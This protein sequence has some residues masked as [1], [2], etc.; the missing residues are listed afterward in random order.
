[1][2]GTVYYV[3]Q[4]TPGSGTID[5]LVMPSY[6]INVPALET[7][8]YYFTAPHDFIIT[9]LR[10][11]V[12][13]GGTVSGIAVVKL[14]SAPPLYAS[15]TNTF[16]T[17]YL[18]QNITGTNVVSVNIPVFSGDIIGVLGERGGYS[19]YGPNQGTGTFSSTL[20]IG[21]STVTLNRMG[22]LYN[23]ATT[24]PQD[25]WTEQV[26][27]IGIVEMYVSKVCNSSLTP[28]SVSVVGVPQVTVTPPPHVCANAAYTLTAGGASTY[29]WTG[30]PQS[31]TYVVNPS[32]T[33]TYSVQGSILSSC[34]STLSTVTITVDASAPTITA[35]ASSASI[36]S[37]NTVS[38]NGTG[39][40]AA[41]FTWNG[42]ANNV[43]NNTPFSPLATQL[44]TLYGTNACGTT[45][46]GITVTVHATP[47]LVTSS[48]DP[49]GV[50]EGNS[51]T[52]TATGASTYSWSNV[53]APGGSVVIIPN[54]G[55]GSIPYNV[56]GVSNAGCSSSTVHILNVLPNPTVSAVSNKQIVCS[57]GSAT[58][59]ASGANSYSW[60]NN[61]VVD[62]TT[63]VNPASTTVYTVTGTYTSNG[64]FA[65]ATVSVT[66]FDPVL[67]VSNSTTVCE[68]AAI[69]LTANATAGSSSTYSWSNGSLYASNNITVTA[70]AAY[71]V[72]VTT[73]APGVFGCKTTA[74]VNVGMNANPTVSI[75]ATK[76]VICK[77][78][79]LLLTASGG[80]T[81]IW[82]SLTPTTNTIF[83]N[84]NVVNTTTGY[85]VTGTD[86]NGCSNTA[87]IG[88]RVNACTGIDQF[89]LSENLVSVY[90]NPNNGIFMIQVN[91]QSHLVLVN[92][93]GQ[94]VKDLNFD[95]SNNYQMEVSD[96]SNGIY[97]IK[98]LSDGSAIRNKIVVSK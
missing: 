42:G 44:Y 40:P 5:T 70:P 75:S 64:C 28:V 76:T 14:P 87:T 60:T 59:T 2:Q 27:T 66:V 82:K 35:S 22:M 15:V 83:V 97:F 43:S 96:L 72:T 93:L 23:L 77:G 73:N 4:S 79:K 54:S 29:T 7:R 19:A 58:L 92:Q 34:N 89:E 71:V 47:T 65:D 52:L 1:T 94:V 63:A 51:T 32:T 49:N 10:V 53:S 6:S 45:T 55:A 85:T 12:A 36:C 61:S 95:S 39:G 33:T 41:T 9:G 8:G 78:E 84:P 13:I 25:L 57:G 46:A 17:L 81:Y 74:T 80:S 38:L 26:N 67:M 88:V 24:A 62:A 37:G 16:S 11:P 50:C 21:G 90:P 31:A 91:T 69:S 68:G 98:D 48:S 56:T 30:G 18:D 3:G 86:A 20:G